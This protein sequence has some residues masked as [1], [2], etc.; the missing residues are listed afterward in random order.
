MI[1]YIRK[2]KKKNQK[3]RIKSNQISYSSSSMVKVFYP[4]NA[5]EKCYRYILKFSFQIMCLIH[6]KERTRV[7]ASVGATTSIQT[8]D[9]T[10][11]AV[12]SSKF[13]FF[14]FS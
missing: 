14:F 13:F 12:S 11:L 5:L 9:T 3:S 7:E 6:A 2:N 4:Y 8:D 1:T 10:I